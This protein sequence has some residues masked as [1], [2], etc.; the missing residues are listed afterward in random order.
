MIKSL[1]MILWAAVAS[2]APPQ[3]ATP[4]MARQQ[5][6]NAIYSA[7]MRSD[8]PVYLIGARTEIDRPIQSCLTP[9]ERTA[10]DWIEIVAEYDAN[11][12]GSGLIPTDL[13]LDRPHVLLSPEEVQEFRDDRSR[14][15][16]ASINAGP[17]FTPLADR[18]LVPPSNPRFQGS[19][20]LFLVSTVYFNRNR[21]L[22]IVLVHKWSN[23]RAA[24]VRW[25]VFQKSANGIWQ[26]G[27]NCV[28][29]IA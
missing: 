29:A 17:S 8:N 7:V 13:K 28:L 4:E 9:A 15:L 2:S 11:K 3:A 23:P 10:Q 14:A 21:S 16:V 18:V 5:D 26:E 1:A 27:R 20:D 24:S 6:I 19:K 25:I 22:A 12:P